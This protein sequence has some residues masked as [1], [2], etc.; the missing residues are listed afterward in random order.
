MTLCDLLS[1]VGGG[2]NDHLLDHA[3]SAVFPIIVFQRTRDTQDLYC[4]DDIYWNS[5][6]N[7]QYFEKLIFYFHEL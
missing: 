7:I 4:M 6:I 5:N 3:K 1:F 2:V